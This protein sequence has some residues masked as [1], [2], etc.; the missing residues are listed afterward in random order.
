MKMIAMM[1]VLAI[2]LLGVT[3]AQACDPASQQFIQYQIVQQST[4]PGYATGGCGS[5]VT[6]GAFFA[7]SGG[8]GYGALPVRQ[9]FFF[10][11]PV[12]TPSRGQFFFAPTT[13]Y[14]AGAGTFI[15][16]RGLINR[17]R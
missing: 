17:I 6:P 16:Q 4:M 10:R 9:Q 8:Y 14:G 1:A 13:G 11:A 12:Y 2:L 15:Q 5:G 7:P 3:T